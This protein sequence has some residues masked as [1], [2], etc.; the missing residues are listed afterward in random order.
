[1]RS[2]DPS[3]RKKWVAPPR[4]Q[5]ELFHDHSG[6]F[7]QSRKVVILRGI[8]S[9]DESIHCA[10]SCAMVQYLVFVPRPPCVAR[11]PY[12]VR[13]H[14]KVMKPVWLISTTRPTYIESHRIPQELPIRSNIDVLSAALL[15][16]SFKGSNTCRAAFTCQLTLQLAKSPEHACEMKA[17][18][19]ATCCSQ[20]KLEEQTSHRARS[21]C[22]KGAP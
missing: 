4:N 20:P 14:A 1:M 2:R 10:T 15:L 13:I 9:C 12:V 11:S 19:S 7:G 18:P 17:R 5:P 21:T 22:K 6:N 16:F 3:L 8:G